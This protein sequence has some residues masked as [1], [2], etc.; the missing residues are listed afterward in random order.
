MPTCTLICWIQAYLDCVYVNVCKYNDRS[1]SVN[2][3]AKFQ[4]GNYENVKKEDLT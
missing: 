3:S 2:D 4:T 1:A